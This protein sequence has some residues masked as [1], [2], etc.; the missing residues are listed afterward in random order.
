MRNLDIVSTN[1]AFGE[2]SFR[3]LL[4]GKIGD[5]G[6]VSSRQY[7]SHGFYEIFLVQDSP[8]IFAIKNSKITVNP[9]EM[10]IVGRNC[11]HIACLNSDKKPL[12]ALSLVLEK[13]EGEAGFYKYYREILDLSAGQAIK[14]PEALFEKMNDFGKEKVC[15]SYSDYAFAKAE[16]YC[17]LAQLLDFLGKEVN[18]QEERKI[19]SQQEEVYIMLSELV[20]GSM[21]LGEI[22]QTLGYSERHTARLI[23]KYFGKNL[24]KIRK[25]RKLETAKIMKDK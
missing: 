25:E 10:I 17:M 22:A 7:H 12:A 5:D 8:E 11:A 3:V 20:N 16:T 24:A 1:V 9:G 4:I 23:T 13:K 21:T 6:D 18:V 15:A 2:A 14:L 19:N